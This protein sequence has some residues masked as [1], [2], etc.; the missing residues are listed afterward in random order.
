MRFSEPEPF[1]LIVLPD[2]QKYARLYPEI[3]SAQTQWIVDNAEGLNIAGVA[4]EGDIVD[5]NGSPEEWAVASE[6]MGILDG[7]VPYYLGVGNHDMARKGPEQTRD[8]TMFDTAFPLSRFEGKKEFGGCYKGS[9]SNAYY[10]LNAGGMKF[11]VLA[12]EVGPRDEVL[13]WANGI[14]SSHSGLRT[15]VVTHIYMYIDDTRV[16]KGDNWYPNNYGNDGEQ[17]WDKFVRKHENIFLVVSGHCLMDGLGKLT[18]E[19]DNG[20]MVHQILANYQVQENGGN[21]MLRIMTFYPSQDEIAVR[22]YSPYADEY[23]TDSDNQFTL[24]YD[25]K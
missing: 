21:G 9:M 17:M 2:T 14:V 8:Y 22:T 20:N 3:F 1:T 23:K 4:H 11:L 7:A 16:T 19:G 12:L 5:T 13:E 6:A 24:S 18:S 15:I 10:Y 25:M